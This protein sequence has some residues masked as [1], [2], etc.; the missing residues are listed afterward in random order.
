MQSVLERSFGEILGI[1]R[2][3]HK[4]IRSLLYAQSV[5][6]VSSGT[7]LS[8][9]IWEDTQVKNHSDA[10]SVTRHSRLRIHYADMK[11]ITLTIDHSPAHIEQRN[12][13]ANGMLGTMK[14]LIPEKKHS[15]VN[16]AKRS[17]FL[18]VLAEY[19]KRRTQTKDLTSASFVQKDSLDL[20]A[21][22]FTKWRTP[23]KNLTPVCFV[24]RCLHEAET[25][26]KRTRKTNR[27]GALFVKEHFPNIVPVFVMKEFIRSKVSKPDEDQTHVPSKAHLC[28]KLCKQSVAL[29]WTRC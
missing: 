11:Y 5:E 3:I 9:S 27:R 21:C 15:P 24:K 29:I 26:K 4:T 12:S 10:Q 22:A 25:T 14:K 7:V 13:R 19:T 18:A 1:C 28:E 23:V 17:F 20:E 8:R 2:N 6:S 16:F